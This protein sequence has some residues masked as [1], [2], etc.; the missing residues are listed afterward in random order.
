MDAG[1]WL[2]AVG[3]AAGVAG[4]LLAAWQVRQHSER[5]SE[6]PPGSGETGDAGQTGGL[7]VGVPFGRLPAEIRGRD[8][9][10]AELRGV[11]T[12]RASVRFPLAR[13]PGRVW[14]LAGM[15]GLGKSTIALAAAQ[16]ARE[17]GWR[18]WWATAT[19]TASLTG[20][21]LE[22]LRQLGAPETVTRPVSSG[23]PAAA[24]RAW[25]YL[26]GPHSA[27]RRWLLIFDNAD[28]PAV[29][30]AP[31]ATSPA[32]HVGWLR[33]DPRGIVIVTTRIKDPR[34]WGPGISL[35]ELS[36][37]DDDA[38]AQ[39][40]ADLAPVIRDPDGQQARELGHRLGGLP[41]ALHLA[42]SYLASPFA[43][44]HTFAE[45][46]RALDSVELP[47]ALADLGDSAAGARTDI[48]R[49]WD[50]SLDALAAD[51]RPQARPLLL[52]LSCYAPATPI[53]VGMLRPHLLTDLLA[54][55]RLS[56]GD[57]DD[58][59]AER[60]RRMRSGLQGLAVAG[61]IDI[62]DRG[63]AQA[64]AVHPV[65]ADAN[66]ARL[67]STS[68]AA[69]RGI[70]DAAL[71]LLGA[72]CGELD[73]ERP[74][75]WPAWHGLVPHILALHEWL[76]DLLNDAALADLLEVTSLA[77]EALVL[78]GAPGTAV[79]HARAGHR[80]PRQ[81]HR[82]RADAA[83][84]PGRPRTRTRPPASRHSD[85]PPSPGAAGQLAWASRNEAGAEGEPRMVQAGA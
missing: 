49:T 6:Q 57:T 68:I 8:A 78:S 75:H 29:L 61:L 39:V 62:A 80:G 30:A 55:G 50:L 79:P 41:L 72:A 7:P 59:E 70:S 37:L 15:G 64:V 13:R 27:G 10:L 69:R 60:E 3:S 53:P 74:A 23:E 33:P 9:L 12:R 40:L 31:G 36:P 25:A 63:D 16:T 48:Q 52:L 22:V 43:R 83:P 32:D 11:P 46:R 28:D 20:A 35:R 44:W 81:V 34:T 77:A 2:S 26:N 84:C 14:V 85:H 18:V 58:T 19:D 71:R 42:G 82:G 38:A 76:A 45:Y 51:R 56:P 21:M 65:V 1:L 54:A 5:R 67:R 4:T 66:R 17:R 47:V 73:R 24:D